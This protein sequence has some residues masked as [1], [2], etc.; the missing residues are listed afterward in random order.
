[1]GPNVISR[2]GSFLPGS[3]MDDC[4]TVKYPVSVIVKF[5]EIYIVINQM[6]RVGY[7]GNSSVGS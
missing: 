5:T 6:K 4:Q 7:H 1:M 2:A 3:L